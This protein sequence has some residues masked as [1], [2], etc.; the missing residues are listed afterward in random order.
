MSQKWDSPFFYYNITIDKA[1]VNMLYCSCTEYGCIQP[2]PCPCCAAVANCAAAPDAVP[3]SDITAR[4]MKKRKTALLVRL[5]SFFVLF[6]GKN[7]KKS[8]VSAFFLLIMS[9]LFQQVHAVAQCARTI[10]QFKTAIGQNHIKPKQTKFKAQAIFAPLKR[11]KH[12]LQLI[13]SFRAHEACHPSAIRRRVLPSL[14][15]P[16]FALHSLRCPM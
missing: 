8:T 9:F 13:H 11:K 3:L 16:L 10:N 4:P 12:F 2:E 5:F 15:R 7:V 1:I 6:W 14:G